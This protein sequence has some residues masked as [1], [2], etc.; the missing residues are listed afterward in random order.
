MGTVSRIGRLPR[1]VRSGLIRRRVALGAGVRAYRSRVSRPLGPWPPRRPVL[2]E[3]VEEL[4]TWN[5]LDRDFYAA[6]SGKEFADDTV[7]ARHYLRW[8]LQRGLSPHPL[9]EPEFHDPKYRAR[10]GVDPFLRARRATTGALGPLFDVATYLDQ[11]PEA[12][13]HPGGALGHFLSWATPETPLPVRPDHVGAVPTLAAVRDRAIAAAR[14]WREQHTTGHGTRLTDDFD[15]AAERDWI[16]RVSRLPLPVAGDEPLVS[17]VIAVRNRPAQIRAAVASV[18]G[19]SLRDLELIVV[20]DGSSDETPEVLHELAGRDYR[21]RVLAGPWRGVCAARNTGIAAARGRYVAFL[22]SDDVYRP[23]FLE[24]AVKAMA[25][26]G[27]RAV[28]AVLDHGPGASPRYLAFDGTHDHLLVKNHVNMISLVVERSLLTAIGGFDESLRRWVDHDLVIRIAR[29]TPLRLLPFVGGAAGGTA[30]SKDRITLTEAP[31]WEYV[32]LAKHHVDWSAVADGLAGRVPGRVSVLIPTFQDWR[33]T[34][35]A[36]TSVLA[37][38]AVEG[39]DVEVVVV[40]NGSRRA[41]SAIL[42]ARFAATPEVTVVRAA[43]NLNFALGSNLAFA[44]S[45]GSTV[46]FLNNDTVVRPGWLRPLVDALADDAVAGAQPLLV[47][48]DGTIQSAGTVF[49]GGDS[50]PHA[51]L[52]HHPMEDAQALGTMTGFTAVTAAALAMRATDVVALRGF[53]PMFINGCE[54]VDLCLRAGAELGRRFAVVTASVVEHLESKTP[55]RSAFGGANRQQFAARWAGR[56]PAPELDRYEAAGFAV[57]HLQPGVVDPA[58]LRTALPVLVRPSRASVAAVDERPP[59]LRWAL[60]IGAHAGPRGDT[61]GDVHFARDLA[62][63]LRRLGQQVVV[64]RRLAFERPTGY[65]DDVTL[66][67]RGLEPYAPGPGRT[68]LLWVISHPDAVTAEEARRYDAVF[69]ASVPWA[70]SVSEQWALDVRPLLQ[71][72]EPSRFQPGTSAASAGPV[73]FL[74]SGRRGEVR[75]IVRDAIQAGVDLHVYGLNWRDEIPARYLRGEYLA[76]DAAGAAYEQARVVLNDHWADMR[77]HGFVSN[78]V[79]DAVAAGG[80]VISDPVEGLTE[81]FGPAV[82]TYSSPEELA[83]LCALEPEEFCPPEALKLV[84][85]EVR[86]VHSFD[87]RARVLLDAAL[88]A[89]ARTAV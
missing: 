21:V 46:V 80:R 9:Y 17:V 69:A 4:L 52:A 48:P 62:A 74:G 33:M 12:V 31:G 77:A 28:H 87:A 30:T 64:D 57:A 84:S 18:L 59:E 27:L 54:D 13:E 29:E 25:G 86:T 6:Q 50:F 82:R 68:N 88:A 55:G 61:W 23:R 89:R 42:A 78:R 79:F 49:A 34:T 45:T 60:K 71:A 75:P 20:D 83:A 53:D 11:H 5:V 73:L 65:L 85:E 63:A 81:L 56:L 14:R 15:A 26:D 43:R 72:T 10:K 22:D 7:A 40:D 8:G 2:A 58:G 44:H 36:V 37:A 16:T 32:V 35:D 67:L 47:Y 51:F 39:D 24:L 1:R 19:Q 76:N 66:T 41:V 3:P 38:A 70:A